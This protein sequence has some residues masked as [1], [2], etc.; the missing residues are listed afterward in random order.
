MRVEVPVAITTYNRWSVG[1]IAAN[2]FSGGSPTSSAWPANNRALYVPFQIDFEY[3]IKRFFWLNGSAVAGNIDMG[4][5]DILGNKLASTG[6][7]AQSG[8]SATQ[9]A[10]ATAEILLAPGSYYMAMAASST[11]MRIQASAGAGASVLRVNG[12][13]QEDSALPLPATFTPAAG[14]FAIYPLMG[15]TWTESGF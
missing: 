8:T 3:R 9:I 4:I 11:S 12:L 13:M 2:G 6:S 5:Y 7:T 1:P 10:N 14:A 15:F